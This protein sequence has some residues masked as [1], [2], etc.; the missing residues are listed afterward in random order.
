MPTATRPRIRRSRILA[1]ALFLLVAFVL[2]LAAPSLAGAAT[3]RR[4]S[5]SSA[6]TQAN[7]HSLSPT[8]SADG[9]FVAFASDATNLVGGDTN[10]A[11]DIF[12]RDRQTGK[13]RRVSVS[14]AG[15]EGNGSSNGLSISA[16]GRF[17]AF[18]S[19]AT[20]LVSGDT[21][22]F[23]DIFVRDLKT[24]QTRRVSKSSSGVQ[25]NDYS[26]EPSI[27]ADGRVVAFYSDATNLVGGDT[28]GA[29]D[30]FVRDLKTNQTRR[31]SKSSAGVQGNDVSSTPSISADGRLVAFTSNATNL[32]G[33]DTNGVTDIFVRNLETNKTKRVSVSSAGAQANDYSNYFPS[34]STD[35][36]F[37]AFGSHASNLVPGDTNAFGDVFLRD[38]RTNRTTRVSIGSSGAQGNGSS[39]LIDPPVIAADGRFV[40]FIS[41]A[42]N[43]VGGTT[44]GEQDFLRDRRAHKTRLL[45]VSSSGVRGNGGSYDPALTPDG[46]FV[47]FP[48]NASNLVGGDTNG[49]ADIFVRG[50]LR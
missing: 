44:T 21:N 2:A 31:V 12:V 48:S 41:N 4:V 17:V 47:A 33:G 8:I 39:F 9:R 36:R 40:A 32:V 11:R 28:N 19:N 6:G 18:Q 37:V 20:N 34:I 15:A 10:G 7:G 30:V 16:D 38:R 3:T 5:L 25:G 29:R 14:S 45:N 23:A 43:L 24:N 27:S 13:T 46:R 22:G 50:P 26:Y 42:T 35:G 49:F 1:P